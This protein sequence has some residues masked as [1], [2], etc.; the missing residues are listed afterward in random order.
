ME[1]EVA[2][3]TAAQLEQIAAFEATVGS[4]VAAQLAVSHELSDNLTSIVAVAKGQL[5][6]TGG[7]VLE[8]AAESNGRAATYTSDAATNSAALAAAGSAFMA[9]FG[10]QLATIQTMVAE[11]GAAVE[12]LGTSV[13]GFL[14]GQVAAVHTF[15]TEHAAQLTVVKGSALAHM[16]AQEAAL[17]VQQRELVA[18]AAR[19]NEAAAAAAAAVQDQIAAMLQTFVAEQAQALVAATGTVAAEIGVAATSSRDFQ[20]SGITH[21]HILNFVSIFEL[22]SRGLV[23]HG[24]QL[25]LFGVLRTHLSLLADSLL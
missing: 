6:A 12:R 16:Q 11:Q 24:K 17:S 21:A 1:S 18:V 3:S 5:S 23:R 20:A 15:A 13:A 10:G 25:Q 22:V 2:L 14:A 4:Q 19:R 7:A 8:H 9:A